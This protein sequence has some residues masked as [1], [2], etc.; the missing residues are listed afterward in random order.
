MNILILVASFLLILSFG[1]ATLARSSSSAILKQTYFT[2]SMEVEKRVQNA[3]QS[4]QFLQAAKKEKKEKKEPSEQSEKKKK[5]Y[6]RDKDV[7]SDLSKLNLTP[8]FMTPQP[9]FYNELYEVAATLMRDL[10]TDTNIQAI[11]KSHS[12]T[13]F[14]Y[15]ILD[16]LI[17]KG[18]SQKFGKKETPSFERL[19]PEEGELRTLYIKM[20]QGTKNYSY[21]PKKGYPSLE[22]FF[23]LDK[24]EKSK[25]IHFCFASTPLL[26]ALLGSKILEAILEQEKEKGEKSLSPPLKK[27]EFQELIL[28]SHDPKI[29]L[30]LLEDL[31]SFSRKGVA[32]QIV[33]HTDPKTRIRRQ[34]S[35]TNPD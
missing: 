32:T 26:K 11:A 15:K 20:L 9:S 17:E 14:E 21:I 29:K 5:S 3:A 34:L 35:V 2:S 24:G 19:A 31:L 25:P 1:A 6:E 8:L 4:K 13:D 7:P 16:A 27:A 22:K 30:P 33:S 23:I 10:Y 28:K 18:K 12:I